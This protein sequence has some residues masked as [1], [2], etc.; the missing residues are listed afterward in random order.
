MRKELPEGKERSLI[1]PTRS[2]LNFDQQVGMVVG[3]RFK[4][5]RPADLDSEVF[6]E[7]DKMRDAVRAVFDAEDADNA[8]KVT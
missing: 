2:L 1:D 5:K 3:V 4:G 6:H 7:G 8:P